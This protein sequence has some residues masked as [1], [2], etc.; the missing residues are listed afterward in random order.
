MQGFGVEPWMLGRSKGLRCMTRTEYWI[1]DV[2]R[3]ELVVHRSPSGGTYASVERFVPGE[4]VTA[5]AGATPVD[6][7]AL[8]AP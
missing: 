7:A 6:V 3:D 2:D 8:L 1:V 5:L 4:I